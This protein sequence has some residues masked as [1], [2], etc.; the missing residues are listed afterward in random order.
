M[1]TTK[2]LDVYVVSVIIP[3]NIFIGLTK[4]NFTGNEKFL[5]R[6]LFVL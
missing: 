3:Y 1:N 4:K 2:T 6:F 5:P